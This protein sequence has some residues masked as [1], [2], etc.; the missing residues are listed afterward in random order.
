MELGSE[1]S[2]NLPAGYFIKTIKCKT[3]LTSFPSKRL[4]ILTK[5]Q[6]GF[7]IYCCLSIAG[8]QNHVSFNRNRDAPQA[9]RAGFG[10]WNT[11]DLLCYSW[12]RF[13]DT[14]RETYQFDEF[15]R[16]RILPQC[17]RHRDWII[18]PCSTVQH[19][20]PRRND[21]LLQPAQTL[22]TFWLLSLNVSVLSVFLSFFYL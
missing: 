21:I 6:A 1:T 11:Q 2:C 22:S 20:D 14:W 7:V 16:R 9:D 5:L 17:S 8:T 4:K 15:F 19:T 10:V 12:G 3:I 18:V 13:M